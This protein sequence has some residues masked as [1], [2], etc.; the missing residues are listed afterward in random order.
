MQLTPLKIVYL[1][2]WLLL[3][4]TSLVS[5]SNPIK[6]DGGGFDMKIF[7]LSASANYNPL[8]FNSSYYFAAVMIY[9]FLYFNFSV[10]II[11]IVLSFCTII[12]YSLKD[13]Q[14]IGGLFEGISKF[15]F[16]PVLCVLVYL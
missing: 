7:W 9:G 16:I 14:A 8:F 1:I 2:S 12:Y 5:Y 3:V 10:L 4:I 15:H 11:F 13:E 6:I